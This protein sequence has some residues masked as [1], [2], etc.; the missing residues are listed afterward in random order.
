MSKT[1]TTKPASDKSIVVGVDDGY[2]L[3]KAAIIKDGKIV[4]VLAIPSRARSGIH[5]TTVIGDD[6][7]SGPVPC[8]ETEGVKFTVGD[9]ADAESARFDD[10]PFSPMNRVIV[11]HLLRLA[12]LA[13]QQVSIATGLPL[14][15]YYEGAEPNAELIARKN[16]SIRT[17]VNCIDESA[18]AN[19]VDHK[20]FPEGLAAW[21]D[22]AIGEDGKM[23]TFTAPEGKQVTANELTIGVIDIGG[24][25]TDVAV[26]LPGRR[27]DH[28]RCGS[29]DIGALNVVEHV[30]VACQ[31]RFGADVPGALIEQ[32]LRTGS[33]KMWGKPQDISEEIKAA[34]SQVMDGVWR[35]ANRRLGQAVDIDQILLVG[36]GVHLFKDIAKRYPNVTIAEAPEFANARGFAKYLNL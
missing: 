25:T 18:T 13:G 5:G 22:Y 21:V 32:A 8:Y 33:M 19:I 9:L 34:V 35:E 30:R 27:I 15:T 4:K 23:R 6:D 7:G 24:R 29:A 17:Q 28:A 16:S 26:V 2:A 10:Y 3:S 36:G 1:I 12:G 14:S 20:V 31:K 11:T